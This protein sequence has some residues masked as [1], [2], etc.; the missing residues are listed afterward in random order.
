MML[1]HIMDMIKSRYYII[2]SWYN[3]EYM[4]HINTEYSPL[5]YDII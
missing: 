5:E 4:M 2:Y 3:Q 1:V